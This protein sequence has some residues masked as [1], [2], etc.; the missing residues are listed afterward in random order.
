MFSMSLV[1]SWMA[2][3]HSLTH[4]ILINL[5]IKVGLNI[6]SPTSPA[7]YCFCPRH[8]LA[9]VWLVYQGTRGVNFCATKWWNSSR[10]SKMVFRSI[11]IQNY[12]V[13]QKSRSCYAKEHQRWQINVAILRAWVKVTWMKSAMMSIDTSPDQEWKECSVIWKLGYRFCFL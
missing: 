12:F 2:L 8:F 6:F 5:F 7:K 9:Y 11:C 10:R 4:S 13:G 3:A 1:G